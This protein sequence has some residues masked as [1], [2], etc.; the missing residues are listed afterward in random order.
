M[1]RLAAFK[2]Y[3]LRGRLGIDLDETL[4]RRAGRAFAQVTRAATAVVGRDVRPS[5]SALQA[6]LVEGLRD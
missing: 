6:A 2:S 4:M 1:T 3:D 5:S